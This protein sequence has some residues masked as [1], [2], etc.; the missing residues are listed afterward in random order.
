MS[1][2][3]FEVSYFGKTNFRNFNIRFGIK[4][5]D[6]LFHF[7]AL[8]KTGS[9]KTSLLKYLMQQDLVASRGFTFLDVHGDACS[10]L[11]SKLSDSTKEKVIYLDVTNPD[12][13]WGYNPFRKVKP[14]QRSLVASNILE[15][16]KRN[17]KSAWGMKMEHILRYCLL[18]LLE[19]PKA[20]FADLSRILQDPSFRRGCL[21]HVSN[22]DIRAFWELEFPKYRPGDL[23]PILNKTGAFLAHP[24]VRKV[25]VENSRQLSLRS[26]MDKEQVLLINLAKGQVGTDVAHILGSLLLTSLAS[27]AFSRI[28]TPYHLRKPFFIYLDEFQTLSNTDLLAEM[29]SELRKFKVGL[30]LANQFLSQLEPE[31]RASLLGNVGTIVSFRCSIA[32][33]SL[34]VKEFIP[35]GIP[36][37]EIADFTSLANF[38][39]YLKLMINGKPSRAFSA[40]TFRP[41]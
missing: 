12:L 2:P 41:H 1:S 37:Y 9:G 18:T 20:N 33:A 32:D 19:Q 27:S 21:N 28:D 11:F 3:S 22:K 24:M 10:E 36:K 14:S 17:W 35:L 23:L 29:L 40:E 26:I 39:V 8:G 34:L 4:Q 15:I 30:I 38:E 13:Q 7:Y 6:R 31:V 16:L 25:L 5:A